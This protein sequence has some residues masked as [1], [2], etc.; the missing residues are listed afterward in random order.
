MNQKR[1]NFILQPQ[2]LPIYFLAST[3]QASKL[4]TSLRRL[5]THRMQRKGHKRNLGLEYKGQGQQAKVMFACACLSDQRRFLSDKALG[6]RGD[7]FLQPG[8]EIF[9]Q[10]PFFVDCG[11]EI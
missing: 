11:E 3:P 9:A 5:S 10:C 7:H 4:I 6:E 1:C 2:S 8:L